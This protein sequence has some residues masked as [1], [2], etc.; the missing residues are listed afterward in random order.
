MSLT[1]SGPHY[2]IDNKRL[3]MA[4]R[5]VEEGE[6]CVAMSWGGWDTHQNN[7]NYL[8]DELPA[9]DIGLS[10]LLDDLRERGLDKDVSVIFW[11]EF[12]RT[13][14]INKDAGRDH[15]PQVSS[16]LLAGGGM[17]TRRIFGESDRLTGE[18]KVP[19][20]LHQTHATLYRAM[21]I[22]ADLAY[23]VE[24]RPFHVTKDGLGKPVM[25]LFA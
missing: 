19:V 12:G 3:V 14:R 5:L 6:R 10:A 22:P 11:V 24:G 20:H 1:P 2:T 23:T 21:G 18:S 4:R 25:D 8:R 13:P 15:W 17:R 9:L 16:A 7:F